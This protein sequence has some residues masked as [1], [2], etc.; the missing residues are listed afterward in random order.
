MVGSDHGVHHVQLGFSMGRYGGAQQH[1]IQ[2]S[3]IDAPRAAFTIGAWMWKE[4]V[5]LHPMV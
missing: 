5:E 1:T 4:E 3:T 2:C